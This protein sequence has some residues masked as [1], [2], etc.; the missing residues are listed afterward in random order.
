LASAVLGASVAPITHLDIT[1]DDA[2]AL[3]AFVAVS[4]TY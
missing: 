1:A 3:A 4:W 2:T